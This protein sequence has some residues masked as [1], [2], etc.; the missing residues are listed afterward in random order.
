MEENEVLG[1][2][3]TENITV[4]NVS[5]DEQL[6]QIHTDLSLIICFIIFFVLVVLL[7]YV[8]K[9]FDMCFKF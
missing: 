5:Y 6:Q 1:N 3:T 4:E 2:E 9:F 7:K 8:Y